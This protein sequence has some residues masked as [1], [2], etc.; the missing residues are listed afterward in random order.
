MTKIKLAL[1]YIITFTLMIVISAIPWIAIIAGD[2]ADSAKSETYLL[3]TIVQEVNK[4]T[5]TVT[6]IDYNGNLWEFYGV[7][8]W[9]KGDFATMMMNTCGTINIFDDEIIKVEYNGNVEGLK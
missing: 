1:T 9:Q 3:N 5:D 4:E 8:D 2:S 6:C 7:E